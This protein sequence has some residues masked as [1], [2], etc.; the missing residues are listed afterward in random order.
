MLFVVIGV[1]CGFD[2]W[3]L[4]IVFG[5]VVCVVYLV[6]GGIVWCYV[7][8]MCMLDLVVCDLVGVDCGV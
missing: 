8:C 4:D 7:V 3:V 1:W 2:E 5:L 6:V